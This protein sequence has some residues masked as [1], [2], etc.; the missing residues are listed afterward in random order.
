MNAA[1]HIRKVAVLGA[2]VMGAQIAA[3]L[4]NAQVETLLFEL[5]ATQGDANGSVHL[6]LEKLKK[7]H[8]APLASPSLLTHIQ[9]ANYQ[10][11]LE[12]LRDCDL[13]I[14]AIA[15]RE[16]WKSALYRQVAPY[17]QPHAI[18]AS[19]T[20]GLSIQ[21]LAQA[22]PAALRA[23]FCGLHFFN[24]PRYMHLVELIPT[25]DTEAT[26]LDQLE[27]F[28][29]STLGKGVVRAKD[30]PNF[31]ANRIGVFSLL[32]TAHHAAAFNLGFDTVDALTGRYLGRPKSATFRTLDVVGLDVFAH[33]VAT[34]RDTLADDPW[35]AYFQNPAWLDDL[36]A[37]GAL[38]QKA[39][40][41][42]YQKIGKEIQ[43]LDYKRNFY[44]PS[45]GKVDD[46]VQEILRERDW[47]KK[48]TALHGS[49]QPQAQF[50]WAILRDVFHYCAVQLPQIADTARDVDFAVRWGFGWDNGPFEIW[51][52]AGWQTI[53]AWLNADI[54]AGKTLSSTP[55]P[56]WAN[57][58][59]RNGVHTAQG[60]F[61]PHSNSLRPR[62]VLPV[63]ARQ[64]FPETLIG[65][66]RQY[67]ETVFEN[68]H[69]RLWHTG[70]QFAILSFQSKMHTLSNAV[71]D[72]ILRAVAE[73]EAHFSALIVWQTEPPFSYGANLLQLMQGV[74]TPLAHAGKF[75]QLK[76]AASRAKYTVAG[77]GGLA[78]VLNAAIGNVPHVEAVLAKFQQ[79]SQRLKYA[80]VP[81]IAAVDGL[82]LGGGCEITLHC[83]RIVA[84]LESYLGLVEVGVGLLPAGGGCTEMAQRAAAEAQ[85]FSKDNRVDVF[86]YLRRYFQAIALGEVSKSAVHAREMGY[87]KSADRIVM[88][89][90][91]LLHSAKAE[92]SALTATAYRPPL[93]QRQIPVAGRTGIATFKASAINLREGGFISE[94][95]YEIGCRVAET[96][97][98]GEV[99]AGSLV[100]EQWLLDLERQH[101]MALLAS[102]K[103][104]ARI[105]HMLKH[106]KPLRN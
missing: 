54:A 4:L 55:L 35:H 17:L 51:Q 16:D 42:I 102:D 56:E 36:L 30:T 25:A 45:A 41:G 97:C 87:L 106:G 39:Q 86:P 52:A 40:C 13:I 26:L 46:S 63:Y 22:L 65:E 100:D 85:Y 60:S 38:G 49:N 80:L 62:S 88:N 23:R 2:G 105:E 53:R 73:A 58:Q 5:P 71:L 47:A 64:A 98:G 89:R 11:D 48:I 92:A 74:Q 28:L 7:Q 3:H 32:A 103:T 66:A 59:N 19:N 93:P 18:L 68:A 34:L 96:V 24:P 70:D 44:I 27:T 61:A 75:A 101:F 10:Q 91:E 79:V 57:E 12:K 14:E 37:Q 81:T 78:E 29:V 8:P 1:L 50:L 6:A 31:I 15:E 69:L 9:A 95:D 84:T 77:G 94:H 21:H 83:T 33:V 20:S 82:A 67:G 90:F 99:D 76:H 104:Q 43:V 72:G